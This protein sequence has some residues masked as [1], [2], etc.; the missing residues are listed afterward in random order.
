MLSPAEKKKL[1]GVA[2]RL[3]AAVLVGKAGLTDAVLAE[4][5]TALRRDGLVKAK[6]GASREALA[7]LLTGIEQRLACERVGSVGKTASFYR[8]KVEEA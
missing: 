8:A 7:D 4:L 1:R 2:Q 6:F 5:D 3:P